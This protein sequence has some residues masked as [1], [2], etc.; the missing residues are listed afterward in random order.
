MRVLA[1][2]AAAVLA[3]TTPAGELGDS[4]VLAP[5]AGSAAVAQ[6]GGLSEAGFRAYLPQLRAQ[7][8]RAGVS[9][10]TIEQVFPT[11]VFSPR[12]VELDRAQPGG[13]GG[14]SANPP[15]AP[16]RARHVTT[17]LVAQGR[18]RY[19]ANQ[20]RLRDIGRRFGVDPAILVA[21]WGK[22][23][24]FGA[25][26]GDFDLLNS[27]ASLAYEGRRRQLFSTEF[28]ATLR[29]LDRGIPRSTLRGS[30]A[31][32]TGHPQFLPSVYI[33]LAVD[34]DGDGRADIWNSHIDALAS[35]ANYL[36]NAGWKPNVPW[37]VPASVPAGFDRNSVRSRLTAPRC[38]RVYD[39]HSRW[40]SVAEW[41]RRG[42]VP[43]GS[44]VSD[45]EMASLIEPDG[46]GQ[47]AYL[48]TN[49]YRAILDYNCSNF[50]A[51]SVA[52]LAD[53]IGR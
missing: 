16:Y 8:E 28:V 7:A 23:T 33:R 43:L 29:M 42:V 25:I 38:A 22:E 41:R 24:S 19:L 37:G 18:S 5:L 17:S 9:R 51:L 10:A 14:S 39:R 20:P 44:R 2:T 52:L 3:L 34:G 21:I 27:L 45:R 12:T 26:R 36:S 13:S 40:L 32:A 46:P 11:L 31:G 50:Y 53:G 47:T 4:A 35:I 48:L 1:Y 30:W 49:N 6:S 15:F